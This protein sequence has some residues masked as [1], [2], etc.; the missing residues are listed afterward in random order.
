MLDKI[1]FV[2]F[3][4]MG[5]S[6]EM[7][8]IPQGKGYFNINVDLGNFEERTF[9]DDGAPFFSIDLNASVTGYEEGADEFAFKAEANVDVHFSVKENSF[10]IT[11]KL[12]DENEWFFDSYIAIVVKQCLEHVLKFSPIGGID[13][14]AHKVS[15]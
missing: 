13:I 5:S 2:G 8:Q 14:P 4:M 15:G 11:D 1:L 10:E 7:N 6:F 12:Y 3:E 9:K